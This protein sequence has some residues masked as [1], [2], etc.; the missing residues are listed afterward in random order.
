MNTKNLT[1]LLC[2][3]IFAA[4]C[5]P[6]KAQDCVS[7][8]PDPS[9]FPYSI[10]SH[11]YVTQTTSN[12][13][14]TYPSAPGT[15][16]FGN[17]KGLANLVF[18]L[19]A[20]SLFQACNNVFP[21][22]TGSTTF[23]DT[24]APEQ[25]LTTVTVTTSGGDPSTATMNITEKFQNTV[26]NSDGV[27]PTVMLSDDRHDTYTYA[28][29]I[30]TGA[31]TINLDANR[32]FQCLNPSGTGVGLD[33]VGQQLAYGYGVWP[34]GDHIAVANRFT[35]SNGRIPAPETGLW[36]NGF[37]KP[38]VGATND[39]QWYHQTFVSTAA[40]IN[41][42]VNVMGPVLAGSSGTEV[43]G[44][45]Y[46]RPPTLLPDVPWTD[47]FDT[48][49]LTF[50]DTG[51]IPIQ[52][53]IVSSEATSARIGRD[54]AYVQSVWEQEGVGFTPTI[55]AIVDKSGD[56][57][58]P[59]F[60]NFRCSQRQALE[61]AI[62]K[63]QGMIN[64]YYV[65][66]VEGA[67]GIV[68]PPPSGCPTTGPNKD[69]RDFGD[70]VAVISAERGVTDTLVHELGHD[71]SLEHTGK[72]GAQL[73]PGFNDENIMWSGHLLSLGHPRGRIRKYFSEGQTF[74]ANFNPGSALNTRYDSVVW[75]PPGVQHLR[76]CP[77]DVSNQS[78]ANPYET[79]ACPA[80]SR[81]V[82]DH[83]IDGCCNQT[84]NP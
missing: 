72:L 58:A 32:H 63:T 53:W 31:F 83:G 66:R 81:Y 29:H 74:R 80:L 28:Y 75:P 82:R 67:K 5:V 2:G 22:Q 19:D 56:R 18:G 4:I 36:I 12:S 6:L 69:C 62:G 8:T 48:I 40:T 78:A 24:N 20:V 51:N 38:S 47:G 30:G 84:P 34:I 70:D 39:I 71:L 26:L 10:P 25:W 57:A 17:P 68:C 37:V 45:T 64:V 61:T 43:V 50:R 49:Q 41:L 54:M 35:L 27:C 46:N 76:F 3:L 13:Q 7:Y 1:R 79:L 16:V 59:L 73:V 44:F 23:M 77:T 14:S 33:Q 60:A 55:A 11:G 15:A 42:R 9:S 65:D 21:K 52:F